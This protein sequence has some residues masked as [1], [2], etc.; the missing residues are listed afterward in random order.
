MKKLH[1]PLND[2]A[3]A[4]GSEEELMSQFRATRDEVKRRVA[5]LLKKSD[6]KTPFQINRL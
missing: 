5:E 2:P 4:Q 3:R 1:W 6:L